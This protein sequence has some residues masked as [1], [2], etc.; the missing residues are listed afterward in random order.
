MNHIVKRLIAG[1]D[2]KRELEEL[3][4]SEALPAG[5]IGCLVGSL[6][7]AKLRVAGAS[8]VQ[9]IEGP[10]EIVSATGTISESGMH[11]HIAVSNRNGDTYGG[12]LVD[13]CHV[14]TTVEI[15]ILGVSGWRFARAN[16]PAT[17]YRELQAYK[18]N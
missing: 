4:S 17:G 1:A 3:A 12:H 14:F 8:A 15:V 5:I 13:G 9:T 6:S 11:V 2:L 7:Q 10:L 16:D 18:L